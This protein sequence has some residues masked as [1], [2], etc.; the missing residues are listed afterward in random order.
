MAAMVSPPSE[1][2]LVDHI[3]RHASERPDQLLYRF[4][5]D[6]E[7]EQAALTFGEV[8]RRARDVAVTLLMRWNRADRALL[9]FQ[10]G[11]EFVTAFLGCLY[12]GIVAV[13]VYPPRPHRSSFERV[14]AIA[15]DCGAA[16]V[17]TTAPLLQKLRASW[18]NGWEWNSRAIATDIIGGGDASSWPRARPASDDVAFLQYTSGTTGNPKG[19]VI[20][21]GNLVANLEV[22][23]RAMRSSEASRGVT[24]LPPYHDMGLI[25]G[26]LQPA[27]AGFPVTLLSPADFVQKPL[28][29]LEAVAQYRATISGG[30]NFAYELVVR[31]TSPEQ[32][33]ALDLSSWEVAFTGAEPVRAETVDRFIEAFACAKLRPTSVF[34][35]YGMAEAT[36]MI[37]GGPY[38][39]R[40]RHIV[41]DSD[42]VEK[43]CRI[44][45]VSGG[46][47][48][49]IVSCGKPW[50]GTEVVIVDPKTSTSVPDWVLGEI[51]VRGDGIAPGYWNRPDETAAVFGAQ[52][53]GRNRGRYLRS[54][55]LGFIVDE[56]IFVAGRMKEIIIIRGRNYFAH[57]IEACVAAASSAFRIACSVAIAVEMSRDPVPRTAV[58]S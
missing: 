2:C 34:P 52:L 9:I 45:A 58:R 16:V 28:R 43:E 53:A 55:D 13:P 14:S 50:N 35:C 36:L 11:L 19:V 26:I 33:A 37:T 27:Y 12:A 54:G 41:V 10:P 51:W 20:T 23:H 39:T 21:H 46:S 29:W 15:R 57:D 31:K 6:G 32:R 8:D 42:A 22:I 4:L 49:T 5:R 25:G 30:P 18:P 24:W 38:G 56:E 17:L 1:L 48:R 44:A 40:A 47:S 3:Q 7:T